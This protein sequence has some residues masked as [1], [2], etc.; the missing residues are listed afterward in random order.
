VRK[1]WVGLVLLG[2]GALVGCIPEPGVST[3]FHVEITNTPTFAPS[4]ANG[5]FHG[6]FEGTARG[7]FI[8]D[9]TVK[10]SFLGAGPF[11][12]CPSTSAGITQVLTLIAENGDTLRQTWSGSQCVSGPGQFHSTSSYTINGGTGRFSGATGSGTVISDFS[13]ST[14]TGTITVDGTITFA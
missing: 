9:G 2:T 4:D 12:P 1:I 5:N 6:T 10:G 14:G 11:E 13:L 7:T 3:P 8:G